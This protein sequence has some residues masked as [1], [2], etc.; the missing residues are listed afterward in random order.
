[1]KNRADIMQPS[2]WLTEI[3]IPVKQQTVRTIA[4]VPVNSSPLE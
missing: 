1:V 2:Q 3:Y 4:R